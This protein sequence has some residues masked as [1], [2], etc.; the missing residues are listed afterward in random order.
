LNNAYLVKPSHLYQKSFEAYVKSYQKAG[1]K[2]YFEKYRKALEDFPAY[3][4]DLEDL[5]NGT[6]PAQD[7]VTTSTF[8]LID[9]E[10]VVGV[11]RIRHR[12]DGS[13]GH[14]GYDISP[15][16]RQKGF[17]YCILTLALKSAKELGL[18]EVILT[19]GIDNVPSRKII[20][21]CNGRL[22]GTIFDEENQ[23]YLSKYDIELVE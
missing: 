7:V 17:G 16:M 3:L 23:E 9:Q 6:N 19:C 15:N 2:H 8:W 22:L 13:G 5:S 1:D 10:S 18:R 21:K 20:E 11:V 14:I 12:E 4:K